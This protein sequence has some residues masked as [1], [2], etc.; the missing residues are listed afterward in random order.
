MVLCCSIQVPVSL[1]FGLLPKMLPEGLNHAKV[2]EHILQNIGNMT[3]REELCDTRVRVKD[4]V[5]HCHLLILAAISSFFENFY[6]KNSDKNSWD[7]TV[8]DEDVSP[9]SFGVF[10]EYIYQRENPP[11]HPKPLDIFK[12]FAFLRIDFFTKDFDKICV[13]WFKPKDWVHVWLAAQKYKLI[14]VVEKSSMMA[15]EHI[16]QIPAET[17]VALHKS[18]LMMLLSL[19]KKLTNDGI[20]N[21]II[22]WVRHDKAGRLR[23]LNQLLQL[24]SFDQLDANFLISLIRIGDEEIT[25]I[26][27]GKTFLFLP[28][29][30]HL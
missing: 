27:F 29:S 14:N 24:I 12:C 30:L 22:Y 17:F 7:I 23:F 5:F 4:Q 18:M 8:D 9:E 16:D 21:K 3:N 20:F 11:P 6:K 25:K 13:K 26:F 2:S 15:A 19:Q 10:L 1:C 28:V